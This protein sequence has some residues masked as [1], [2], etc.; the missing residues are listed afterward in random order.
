M[1]GV[2]HLFHEVAGPIGVDDAAVGHRPGVPD[3][4][5][6]DGLHELVGDA[7]AVVGILEKDRVVGFAAKRAVVAHF[8]ESPG[9]LFFFHLAVD[10]FDDVGVVDVE[11]YHLGGATGF[12]AGL[13]DAGKGVVAAHERHR[14]GGGAAAGEPFLG[15][16][17]GG[18]VGARAGAEL[19]EHAFG[20][21]QIQNGLHLILHRVDEAG[22]ALRMIF[23]AHVE[24]HRAV[25]RRLLVHQQVG[26]FRFKSGGI[27]V[28]S[29]IAV[30]DAPLGQCFRNA[31]HQLADAGLRR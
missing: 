7:H 20:F 19:E 27:L 29:K 3:L 8:D 24:P 28:R 25:K 31:V 15:R 10:V 11:N 16:T 22:G 14:S 12:A 18:K 26:H 9:F 5:V 13:D 23:H 2:A 4:V 1:G 30:L 17:Q 6:G 21:G